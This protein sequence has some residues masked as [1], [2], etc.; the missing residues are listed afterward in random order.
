MKLSLRANNPIPINI[1]GNWLYLESASQEVEFETSLGDRVT[2]KKHSVVKSAQSVGRVLVY[3]D[4]DQEI[5]LEFGYGDFVPP[6]NIDGQSVVVSAMPALEIADG[7]SVS[8][9]SLPKVE[10]EDGQSLA[11]SSLPSVEIAADQSIKVSELP[12]VQIAENQS[13]EVVQLPAVEI[14]ADQEIAQKVSSSINAQQGNLP[15]TVAENLARQKVVI[16]ASAS[17]SQSIWVAGD[18]PLEAGERLELSTRTE[19]VITGDAA[20]SVHIIEV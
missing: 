16:K 12:A 2:V 1:A 17:N 9:D 7:Q 3:S 11:V 6:A 18:F 8:I 5:S 15:L 14:A 19:L 13:V 4:I 20:D 10:I